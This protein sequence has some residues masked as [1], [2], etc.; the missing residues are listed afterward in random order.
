MEQQTIFITGAAAGIGAATA[1]R[2]ARGGWL[3][4][5]ADRDAEGL[6]RLADELGASQCRVH[7]LDVTDADAFAVELGAFVESAGRLD[8]LF[9]N[10]GVLVSDDFETLGAGRYGPMIDVN[11]K[12]VVNG[13]LA[14]FPHLKATPGSRLVNTCS[15]SAI[16][17][18]PGFAVYSATKFAVRGLT[19]ALSVEWTRHGITACDILPMF[20]GTAMIESVGNRTSMD[21]MGVRLGPDDVAAAAWRAAHWPRWW[22]RIHFFVGLQAVFLAWTA[23]LVPTFLNR[24]I[25]RQITG[26]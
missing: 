2:F 6:R 17:G 22:P 25:T 14:A 15:A 13:A 19:E 5:L 16:F 24:W 20:V 9:N 21:R 23:R 7:V 3:V 1:R 10:A 26:Y 4:G 18:A 11:L 8:L 12:G